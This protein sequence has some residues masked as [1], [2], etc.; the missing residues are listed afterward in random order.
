MMTDWMG[1]WQSDA[2][3][4]NRKHRKMIRFENEGRY[5]LTALAT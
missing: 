5:V 4:Q 3:Y 2:M 1:T